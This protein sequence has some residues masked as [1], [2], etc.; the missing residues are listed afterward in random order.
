[1]KK[2]NKPQSETQQPQTARHI[3]WRHT[4]FMK[5]FALMALN[6]AFVIVCYIALNTML[7]AKY[8]LSK[9]ENMLE[10]SFTRVESLYSD[11]DTDSDELSL[12]LEKL[13]NDYNVQIMVIDSAENVLYSTLPE[14]AVRFKHRPP[15]EPNADADAGAK[16]ERGKPPERSERTVLD[17][18]DKYTIFSMYISALDA[19]SLELW[20]DI[21]GGRRVLIQASV[22]A[23]RE[24][25][26]I[27]NR[28]WLFCGIIATLCALCIAFFLSRRMTERIKEKYPRLQTECRK[29]IFRS[30]TLYAARTKSLFGARALTK[31]RTSWKKPCRS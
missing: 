10:K 14:N 12:E 28:F 29:W 23:I 4:I 13:S 19:S 8:Y 20:G 15:A 3:S 2:R 31:C 11:L 16:G 24:S 1:M 26:G 5:I 6:I 7:H 18:T 17:K 27:S 22:A 25:I 9:K 21:G 30:S